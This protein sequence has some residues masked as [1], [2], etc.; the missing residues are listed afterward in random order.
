MLN[1][2]ARVSTLLRVAPHYRLYNLI[3]FNKSHNLSVIPIRPNLNY[4]PTLPRKTAKTLYFVSANNI[5]HCHNKIKCTKLH[6]NELKAIKSG[7]TVNII[8]HNTYLWTIAAEPPTRRKCH[9]PHRDRIAVRT[10][11]SNVPSRAKDWS[12][13]A[14]STTLRHEN[15]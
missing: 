12:R 10:R 4:I 5:C 13:S 1:R 11:A 3:I 7:W 9:C 2:R 8:F 15:N 14:K 6:L